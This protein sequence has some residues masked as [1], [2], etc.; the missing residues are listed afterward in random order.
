MSIVDAGYDDRPANRITE[1]FWR[2]SAFF[3]PM[4]FCAHVFAF[5][6]SSNMYWY[7]LPRIVLVPPLVTSVT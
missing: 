4:A 1:L 6:A 2:K 3:A 5:N 7:A